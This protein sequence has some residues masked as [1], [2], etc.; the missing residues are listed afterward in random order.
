M[1]YASS[2]PHP[3]AFPA[4]PAE[5]TWE[6]IVDFGPENT[7]VISLISFN[8]YLYAATERFGGFEVWRSNAQAPDDPTDEWTQVVSGGAGDAWNA[9]GGTTE[10]FNDQLYVGSMSLPIPPLGPKGFDLIRIDTGDH[11]ELIVG[12]YKPRA[13]TVPRGPP[14]SGWPAGFANPLNFYC[15]S[16]EE[17]CGYLYLGTFD[18]SAFLRYIAPEMIESLLDEETLASIAEE[19]RNSGLDEQYVQEL[20]EILDEGDLATLIQ[21]LWQYLG[22]ADLWKSCDGVHWIP[23]SLNGFDNPSNYGFRTL[24]S[25]SDGLYVGTANPWEG[26]EVWLGT[27]GTVVSCEEDGDVRFEF[28]PNENVYVKGKSFPP[29]KDVM[30]Y[31]IP[32]G[33]DPEPEND[34]DNTG[35][36]GKTDICGKLPVTLVWEAPLDLGEY[37]VWV[38][39]NQNGEFDCCDVYVAKAVTCYM[40]TVVPEYPLGT[41]A[42]VIAMVG[43]LAVFAL[44]KKRH[45]GI[46]VI[47]W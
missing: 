9:W 19:L 14:L 5:D 4:P 47:R 38:D 8:G 6:K 10:V 32:D 12:S 29:C 18:A 44:K 31:V 37:D 7:A 20:L 24:V 22:G 34:V 1:I 3:G 25:T 36:P 11:W 45:S 2:E 17:H 42:S 28:Y 30:I 43:S 15:W 13:P 35:S 16:L 46:L 39:V 41:V 33:S 21:K 40:F 23:V 27:K 26:C